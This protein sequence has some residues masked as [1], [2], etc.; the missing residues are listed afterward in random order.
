MVTPLSSAPPESARAFD[1]CGVGEIDVDIYVRVPSLPLE[2]EKTRGEPVEFHT[3]GMI[4]NYL[5][6]SR[7]AGLRATYLGRVGDDRFGEQ[8]LA[9]LRHEGVDVTNANVK[10]EQQTFFCVILHD[11]GSARQ[12]VT[13]VTPCKDYGPEDIHAD[14][15]AATRHVHTNLTE[16]TESL[17][18]RAREHGCTVSVDLDELPA[19]RHAQCVREGPDFVRC[20]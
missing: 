5:V 11:G 9:A 6:A 1:V 19:D 15:L 2:G 17:V 4:G 8:A 10:A 14:V 18:A 13:A 7:R 20:G 16:G 3:G 12:L